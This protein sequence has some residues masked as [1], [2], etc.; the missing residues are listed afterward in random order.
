VTEKVK[1]NDLRS[2]VMDNSECANDKA[3]SFHASL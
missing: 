2:G 1:L 3:E